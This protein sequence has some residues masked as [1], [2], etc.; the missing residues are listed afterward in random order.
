MR[1]AVEMIS[2]ICYEFRMIGVPVDGPT[3]VFFGT[4]SVVRTLAGKKVLEEEAQG[5]ATPSNL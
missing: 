1:V 2:E 4:E 3:D 5:F